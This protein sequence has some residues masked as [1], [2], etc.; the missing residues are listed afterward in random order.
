[1]RALRLLCWVAL[2]ACS[3]NDDV[4]APAIAAV[5]PDRAAPG[6]TVTVT[7]SYLCQQP[8]TTDG[9]VDPLACDHEGSVMFGTAPG[10]VTSY[11]DTA[12]LVEVPALAPGSVDVTVSVAGRGSNRVGFVVE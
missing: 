2:S 10:V 12:V 5:Q 7:G 4:P 1:M 11:T 3:A 6:A 9:D 8:R